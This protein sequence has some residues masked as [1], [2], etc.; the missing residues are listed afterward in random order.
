MEEEKKGETG[1]DTTT[2]AYILQMSPLE[3]SAYRIA[4]GHLGTSFN[5]R[6][7]NGFLKWIGKK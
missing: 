2:D 3:L 7:S 5:L 6:K 1:K 4:K